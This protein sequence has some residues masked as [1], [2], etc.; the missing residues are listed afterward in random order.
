MNLEGHGLKLQMDFVFTVYDPK[1]SE[2][3]PKCVLKKYATGAL[4][5]KKRNVSRML[6]YND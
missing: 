5:E 1:A 2:Q 6:T 4:I 3:T